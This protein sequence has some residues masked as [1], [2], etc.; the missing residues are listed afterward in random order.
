MTNSIVCCRRCIVK[1]SETGTFLSARDDE[2]HIFEQIGEKMKSRISGSPSENPREEEHAV[3]H[4]GSDR[5]GEGLH[6]CH[7]QEDHDRGSA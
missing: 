4:A 3:R 1:N 5:I 2:R 7:G 6:V